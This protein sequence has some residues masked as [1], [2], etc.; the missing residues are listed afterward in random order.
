MKEISI[1]YNEVPEQYL[2][3]SYTGCPNVNDCLRY[4]AY[5]LAPD[6][7]ATLLMVSPRYAE[8]HA[9]DCSFHRPV[10]LKTV[11]RGFRQLLEPL[12]RP[13]FNAFR[14][15]AHAHFGHATYYRYLNGA[16]PLSE[17]NQAY[18]RQLVEKLHIEADPA[19][20]FDASE[21]SIDW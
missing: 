2:H 4:R 15:E 8:A 17:K 14:A 7:Q 10:R 11:A 9:A 16:Q 3:C 1:N 6:T 21:D 20:L 18:I 12:P 5:Q 19:S 13:Q